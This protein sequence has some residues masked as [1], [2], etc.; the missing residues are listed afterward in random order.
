MG[1]TEETRAE[2][3]MICHETDNE[4]DVRRPEVDDA[5]LCNCSTSFTT[6]TTVSFL[7]ICDRKVVFSSAVE[8]STEKRMFVSR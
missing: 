1:N 2:G 5:R 6:V 8:F 4:L 3:P 7:V